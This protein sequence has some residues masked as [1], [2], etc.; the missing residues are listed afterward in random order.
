MKHMLAKAGLNAK[1]SRGL[2]S[3]KEAASAVIDFISKH[4][5]YQDTPQTRNAAISNL[6]KRISELDSKNKSGR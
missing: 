6:S 3:N 4:G 2:K 5:V 1:K